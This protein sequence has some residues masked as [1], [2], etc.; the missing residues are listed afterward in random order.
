MSCFKGEQQNYDYNYINCSCIVVP[1]LNISVLVLSIYPKKG[2]D[3]SVFQ[4]S[5]N[6]RPEQLVLVSVADI[7]PRH[8]CI[9]QQQQQHQQL[10]QNINK[11]IFYIK[12]LGKNN[13]TYETIFR[14]LG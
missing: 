2:V 11:N 5:R 9:I 6:A 13:F 12:I 4:S 3:F 14:E 10:Q 1:L 8:S 7:M